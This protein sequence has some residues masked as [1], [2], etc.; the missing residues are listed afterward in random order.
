MKH[1]SKA[2]VLA[3][4]AIVSL[5][6]VQASAATIT[7][8]ISGEGTGVAGGNPFNTDFTITLTGD[9]ANYGTGLLGGCCDVLDPLASAVVSISG[10]GDFTIAGPTR[11]GLNNNFDVVF[12]GRSEILSDG[13][14]Y[15]DFTID[16]GLDLISAFGVP[17]TNVSA[18]GQFSGVATDGGDLTFFSSSDVRFSSVVGVIP[19]PS[20][21]ALM[22]AGFGLAGGML[23]RRAKLSTSVSY[24]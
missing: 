11:I 7:Y 12:F 16:P 15:F 24:A 4:A 18:L 23:R 14:D 1:L 19:E 13:L 2:A 9:T 8:T 10:L 3:A 21:W 17:G 5:S 6:A 20:S 22:I